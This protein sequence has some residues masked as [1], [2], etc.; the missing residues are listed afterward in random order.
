MENIRVVIADDHT[1]VRKGLC[2][3]LE[4]EKDISVIGEAENG[5]ELISLLNTTSPDV[6]LV[7]IN[8][9]LLNGIDVTRN[10]KKSFPEIEIIILTMYTNEEYVKEALLA[11]ASGFLVKDTVPYDLCSAIR[12]VANKQSYLSPTIS[13]TII[14]QYTKL[15]SERTDRNETLELTLREKEILQLIAEGYNNR[16]IAKMLFIS[17]KTIDVHKQ[18]IQNKLNIYGTARLT[19]YAIMK[20]LIKLE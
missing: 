1:I 12:A 9:P 8:M 14:D 6:I 19:K 15:G 7:D 16:E 18:N 20:G 13:R 2:S 4:G 11:G 10:I 5:R 17:T 3:L